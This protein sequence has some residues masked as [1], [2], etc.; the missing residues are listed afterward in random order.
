MI[1]E[2]DARQTSMKD[3]QISSWGLSSQTLTQSF[4]TRE[5][6]PG[7][8]LMKSMHSLQIW[9]SQVKNEQTKNPKLYRSDPV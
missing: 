8:R 9:R 2:S 7:N 3:P 6:Q 1:H 4:L 5:E